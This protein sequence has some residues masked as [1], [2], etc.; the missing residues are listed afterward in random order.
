MHAHCPLARANDTILVVA[1][2]SRTRSDV[3]RTSWP[4]PLLQLPSKRRMV[5]RNSDGSRT[6][7]LVVDPSAELVQDAM[8]WCA[9]HGLVYGAQNPADPCALVH[10]PFALTPVPFPRRAFERAVAASRPFNVMIDRVARDEG[11]L[12][13]VLEAAARGDAEFTGRLM[14]VYKEEVQRRQ[15]DG[16]NFP[17]RSLVLTRSDYMLHA[18]TSTML[19]VEL[20]TIAS[21]FGCLSTLVGGL[22][23]FILGKAGVD[24]A[25]IEQVLPV[26]TSMKVLVDG[27]A[28]GVEAHGHADRTMVM[29]VQPDE[30]NS[31]D[32]QWLQFQLWDRYGVRTVRKTL[33]EIQEEGAVDAAS[34]DLRIGGRVVGLVYFRAG[35]TPSDYHGDAEWDARRLVER[36]N[37]T[38]CPTVAMQLAGSKKVQQDLA[39]PGVV[40]RFSESAEAAA[41]MRQCFAGLWGLD[42]LD[43]DTSAQQAVRDAIEDPDAFVLKPQREG[44]GNN[45]YGTELRDT[46]VDGTKDVSDLVLMQKILPPSNTSVLVRRGKYE[47]LETLSE[48]GI[49]GVLLRVGEEVTMNEEAGMLVRTKPEVS[50][51]GGVAAGFA[52][53][54]SVQLV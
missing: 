30:Q 3:A 51:E 10:A 26:N 35:Y 33:R 7:G 6:S 2:R 16:T 50:A 4:A 37:A 32:Q 1:S 27:L 14:E 36:S 53:L 42:E 31:F 8:A 24:R 15:R 20:N 52:V 46:L 13:S 12:T 47:A 41:L 44:G 40:E 23:R 9:Q 29:V 17:E 49:Y 18:P 39:K 28:A 38:K 54:D 5:L 45:L 21:S 22:H 48:L 25:T 19:Q 43:T 11:Y 34:G